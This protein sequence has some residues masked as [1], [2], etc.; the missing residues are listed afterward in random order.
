[1]E[2]K[3]NTL[4]LNRNSTLKEEI[5]TE[6]NID[7]GILKYVNILKETGYSVDAVPEKGFEITSIPDKLI[8][9]EIDG[10][11]TTKFIGR[12]IYHYYSIESTNS[13][14][15]EVAIEDEEGT[16][17]MAEEQTAGKGRL[18]RKWLSPLGK[19]IWM[20]VVLKPNINPMKLSPI[21]LLGAAAIYKALKN[22]G[23]D[24]QIKWPNDIIINGKKV[25]GILTESNVELNMIKYVVM[26]IG[27]NVNLEPEDIPEELK[28]KATSIKIEENR[29]IYR[30]DLLVN[31]LDE[32]EKLYLD[33]K[34][35]GDISAVIEICRENSATIGKKVKV[36]RGGREKIGTALDIN[37][38]GEVMVEFTDGHVEAIFSGEVAVIGLDGYI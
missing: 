36:T 30:R 13:R 32:L 25:A 38:N 4:N 16:L 14:A 19:G 9:E 31:L 27:I 15:K 34:V 7:I 12:N 18:D 23:V 29:S 24:S 35:N 5:S 33:F 20:S 22:I 8:L 10:A 2:E 17:V 1:M 26:G 3:K 11:L 21:A 37:E 6:Q 28:S